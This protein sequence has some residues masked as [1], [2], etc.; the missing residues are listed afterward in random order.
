MD[1]IKSHPEKL[2]ENAIDKFYE[3]KVCA[4][5]FKKPYLLTLH[6]RA[7]TGET[8][9]KCAICSKDFNE[10]SGL[11][12]HM[13]IHT[14]DIYYKCDVCAKGFNMKCELTEHV[15]THSNLKFPYKCD[16][17]NISFSTQYHFN[18]HINSR[19][20]LVCSVC[21]KV[22][23]LHAALK[24][25]EIEHYICN[26]CG[27][28]FFQSEAL[29]IH[30]Q[31][32]KLTATISKEVL[33]SPSAL[34][35]RKKAQKYNCILSCGRQFGSKEKLAFHMRTYKFKCSVCEKLFCSRYATT[36]HMKFPKFNC[37]LCEKVFCENSY[38]TCHME[39]H[40]NRGSQTQNQVAPSEMP[41]YMLDQVV[42]LTLPL[43][44]EN[45]VTTSQQIP[46][47][48]GN[49]VTSTSLPVMTEYQERKPSET[50]T[51][52]QVS[53]EETE[54]HLVD[55][56]GESDYPI[57]Q[58][59]MSGQEVKYHT[60]KINPDE[61]RDAISDYPSLSMDI[62]CE[63]DDYII[64]QPQM[65]GQEVKY[66]TMKINPNE[67][68]GP[69]S[70][71]NPML[72]IG[73]KCES[74]DTMSKLAMF[75]QESQCDKVNIKPEADNVI[76]QREIGDQTVI[77]AV[78]TQPQLLNMTI[79]STLPDINMHENTLFMHNAMEIEGPSTNASNT[80]YTIQ[81]SMCNSGTLNPP[82]NIKTS[83]AKILAIYR[84]EK[85][86]M[87][88]TTY[89]L[90]CQHLSANQ[91]KASNRDHLVSILKSHAETHSCDVCGKK[92]S[93]SQACTLHMRNHTA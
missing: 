40:Q 74:D 28:P 26:K 23:C 27:I 47:I 12:Q 51:Q 54:Y 21:Q 64:T 41:P 50:N 33:R 81:Q 43:M 76:C 5:T 44:A 88:F 16:L 82:S 1:N 22:F 78:P 84:C 90:L 38:M 45:Q 35:S 62:K 73:V 63:Q 58:H 39:T 37:S 92:F 75:S 93:T 71:N 65:S 32:C 79:P 34:N 87:T 17:C 42:S 49:H 9:Y 10:N 48:V 69:I 19:K 30:M 59:Q 56:K 36:M 14:E 55:V 53:G 7:H 31:T 83:S 67:I 72:S 13:K 11:T 77:D 66:H 85:C 18:M 89:I 20:S 57:T 68:R 86:H 8:H 60:M 61:I 80:S 6:M 91:C 3:C 2:A 25:H 70:Y 15:R 46:T 52:P 29:A 24:L 4:K